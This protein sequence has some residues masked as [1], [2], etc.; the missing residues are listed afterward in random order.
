MRTAIFLFTLF[1]FIACGEEKTYS[2]TVIPQEK[3]VDVLADVRL[4]E[5]L[6]SFRY[7]EID[8]QKW[9]SYYEQVF[10]RHGVTKEEFTSTFMYYSTHP[11]ELIPV[12]EAVTARLN[13]EL[14]R[15]R[16]VDPMPADSLN[17]TDE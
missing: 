13:A 2:S 14:A 15:Q 9:S 3:F 4:L 8:R 6:N 17:R 5:G 11:E 12:E 16:A 7:K 1:L 10:Q